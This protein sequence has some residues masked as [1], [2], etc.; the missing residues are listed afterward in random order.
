M[1]SMIV[2][3]QKW[4]AFLR[5]MPGWKERLLAYRGGQTIWEVP[6]KPE[7]NKVVPWPLEWVPHRVYDASE[8]LTDVDAVRGF[9]MTEVTCVD[10]GKTAKVG[11][12]TCC[13]RCG[14]PLHPD[15]NRTNGFKPPAC[16]RC[17]TIISFVN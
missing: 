6:G 4:W 16:R 8:T 12:S 13:A 1:S 10:T 7:C 15:A 3:M 11:D 5:P 9:E 2:W 14:V 17:A